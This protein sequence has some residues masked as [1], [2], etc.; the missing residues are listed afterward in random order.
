[1]KAYYHNDIIKALFDRAKKKA[2]SK[3]KDKPEV[4]Q[5]L[6]ESKGRKIDNLASNKKTRNYKQE[7]I[8]VLLNNKN[9]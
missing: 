6:A 9:K 1:M 4:L 5:L 3:I 2:W 7:Q 8:D